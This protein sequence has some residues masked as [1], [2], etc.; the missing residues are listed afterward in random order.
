MA[1]ISLAKRSLLN[2]PSKRAIMER[3]NSRS[4]CIAEVQ[5][6]MFHCVPGSSSPGSPQTYRW[7]ND[8]CSIT[9]NQRNRWW[10]EGTRGTIVWQR[11]RC[12]DE[13]YRIIDPCSW[14]IVWCSQITVW[15]YIA[16]VMSQSF[17]RLKSGLNKQCVLCYTNSN[18]TLTSK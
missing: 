9:S 12:E 1:D 2:N 5:V 3:S 16:R 18:V 7:R 14:N 11:S 6:I 4:I 13:R 15:F 17:G 10:K 8:R